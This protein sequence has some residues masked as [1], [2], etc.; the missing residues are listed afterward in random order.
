MVLLSTHTHNFIKY[1]RPSFVSSYLILFSAAF[2]IIVRVQSE[3]KEFRSV[4]TYVYI[5]HA[6]RKSTY[7]NDQRREYTLKYFIFIFY[8]RPLPTGRC[9]D[10]DDTGPKLITARIKIITKAPN[11]GPRINLSNL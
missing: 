1:D 6:F 9:H 4:G 2:L 3:E 5:P 7:Q 11:T 10:K 8:R